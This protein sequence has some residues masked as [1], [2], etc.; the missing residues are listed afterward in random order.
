VYKLGSIG[1]SAAHPIINAG[2]TSRNNR[3]FIN[4]VPQEPFLGR[5]YDHCSNLES[6]LANA[7]A[8]FG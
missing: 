1:L 2:N 3:R 8:D 6:P 4:R 5:V 7:R